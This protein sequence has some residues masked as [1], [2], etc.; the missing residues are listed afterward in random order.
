MSDFKVNILGCGSAT[1]SL[2]HMPSCQVIDYRDKL[3]MIDCGEGAQLAMRRMKLKYSRLNHIFISHLHGD[4]CLG[5]PGLLSTM[6]LHDIE[7]TI[8]IHTFADGAEIIQQIVDFFCRER[9]YELKFNIIKPENA[10]IYEDKSLIVETFPLYHRVP[11]VGFIFREKPKLRHLNREMVD[12]YN[13]P[14]AMRQA[15]KAGED[16]VTPDGEIIP[17][18]RLTTSAQPSFSYAYCSDTIYNPLVAEAVKGC[19]VIYHEATYDDSKM[20][21]AA[22]RGHSTAGQ[23][24]Q[25]AVDAE[26]KKLIIGHY[27]KSYLDESILLD[28]ACRIFPNTI[29]ANEGMTIDIS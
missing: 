16:F 29:A 15:I 27:S 14:I 2:R 9:P 28:D 23:A 21:K 7:G 26:A 11:C 10:I 6:A 24:A 19:D 1:P 13:V 12:F 18:H 20:G 3:M 22:Q 17:N 8:T 5:L 25:I 4:H